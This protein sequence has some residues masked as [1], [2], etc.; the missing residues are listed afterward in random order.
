MFLGV[1]AG[2]RQWDWDSR[3]ICCRKRIAVS[4]ESWGGAEWGGEKGSVFLP[5]ELLEVAFD[6]LQRVLFLVNVNGTCL[7]NWILLKDLSKDEL[8]VLSFLAEIEERLCH[9]IKY[10]ECSNEVANLLEVHEC[11]AQFKLHCHVQRADVEESFLLSHDEFFHVLIFIL[12]DLVPLQ[13]VVSLEE[14]SQIRVRVVSAQ[15]ALWL[16]IA[17]T[18]EDE[19]QTHDNNLEP[20]IVVHD[21]LQKYALTTFEDLRK[22]ESNRVG[23]LVSHDFSNANHWVIALLRKNNIHAAG[24]RHN[25]LL[26]Q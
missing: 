6:I 2:W 12:K 11:F 7:W 24:D 8:K 3:S 18:E 15:N 5:G 26:I 9:G 17:F 22:S 16:C 23:V 10:S 4:S 1:W 14:H 20:L 25:C 21:I 13:H 19:V